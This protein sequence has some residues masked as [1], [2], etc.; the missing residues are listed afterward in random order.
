MSMPSGKEMT[1]SLIRSS[2]R[3]KTWH[4]TYTHVSPCHSYNK[5]VEHVVWHVARCIN[6]TSNRTSIQIVGNDDTCNQVV[7]RRIMLAATRRSPIQSASQLKDAKSARECPDDKYG[8]GGA[9]VQRD[10][11][12]VAPVTA[13]VQVPSRPP[14]S[15]GMRTVPTPSW[16]PSAS[17]INVK[18]T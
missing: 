1:R 16:E 8:D 6:M 7:V 15:K 12:T 18:R 5:N 9:I 13:Q 14:F 4:P 2:K 11:A 17:S 10:H 3:F